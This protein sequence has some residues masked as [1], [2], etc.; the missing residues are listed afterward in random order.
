MNKKQIKQLM[1][2]LGRS[3]AEQIESLKAMYGKALTEG[4][5]N[6]QEALDIIAKFE[7]DNS[8]P[9]DVK[10]VALEAT[11]VDGTK[12][13]KGQEAT[14]TQK[15]YNAL[16]A[17]LKKLSC[18]AVLFALLF[19]IGVRSANAQYRPIGLMGG[20]NGIAAATAGTAFVD[21]VNTN[22]L[23]LVKS[24]FVALQISY[25]NSTVCANSSNVVFCFAK[26][27]DGTPDSTNTASNINITVPSRTDNNT[28][29]QLTTNIDLGAI[30]YMTLICRSNF[31]TN[32]VTNVLIKYVDGSNKP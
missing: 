15:Q 30:G 1:D 20:T 17:R 6:A 23:T 21:T 3:N 16:A 5:E 29:A 22:L 8:E 7:K 12:L 32:V 10:V 19:G 27:L 25:T 18:I 11:I 26:S 14:V 13:S 24:R 28:R 4:D 2:D 31:C 9:A